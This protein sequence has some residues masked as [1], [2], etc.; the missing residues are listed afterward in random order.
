[1]GAATEP[2]LSLLRASSFSELIAVM[3]IHGHLG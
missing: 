2:V 3:M 1:L